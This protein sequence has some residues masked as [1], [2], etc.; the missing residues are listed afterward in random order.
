MNTLST[1]AA[2]ADDYEQCVA[3][4][5]EAWDR[6]QGLPSGT[7]ARA[8][9]FEAWSHAISR[10]NQAWRR[11]HAQRMPAPRRDARHA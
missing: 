9:A 6:M 5:R 7:P 11:A 2:F 3:H 4:E 10:T 8:Q 1:D